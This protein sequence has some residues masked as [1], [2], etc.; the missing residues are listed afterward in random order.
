MLYNAAER[1]WRTDILIRFIFLFSNQICLQSSNDQ[2]IGNL[3]DCLTLK[4]FQF[5]KMSSEAKVDPNPGQG[6]E[7]SGEQQPPTPKKENPASSAPLS[8]G[9]TK[10]QIS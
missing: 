10:K 1:N 3:V 9:K 7:G 8:R 4:K 6:E 5:G 2:N